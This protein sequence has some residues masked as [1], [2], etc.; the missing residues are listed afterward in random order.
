MAQS[1]CF[2][3]IGDSN[4]LRHMNRT[5]CR[6]NPLMSS[7]QVIPCTRFAVFSEALSS[8]RSSSNAVLISCSTNF[9]S[10]ATKEGTSS[11]SQ[12][13]DPVLEKF[14][15]L[16][17]DFSSMSSAESPCS[18]LVAPPMYRRSPIWYRDGLSVV[19]TRFSDSFSTRTGSVHLL[20]SFPTPEFEPDGIHVTSYSGLEF[21][22]H[23][24]DSAVVLLD[25]L[26]QSSETRLTRT[27][28]TT[29]LL[30]DRV[31]ILEQD[32]KRLNSVVELKSASIAENDDF[33]ENV[34]NEDQFVISGLERLPSDLDTKTWQIRAKSDV[35]KTIKIIAG[36][37][38][39][40]I[41]VM[42]STGRRPDALI[43][44]RVRMES[45]ADSALVRAKF[46]SFFAGGVDRRPDSLR[47][48]SVR[49]FVTQG[50]RVRLAIL[51]T[52]ARRYR[53]ANSEGRAQVIGFESRPVLKVTPP[54]GASNR[55]TRSYNY[56]EAIKSFPTCFT[57]E[58]FKPI[59]D[60]AASMSVDLRSVFVI[61][62][63][64][65]IPQRSGPSRGRNKRGPQSPAGSPQRR[66]HAAEGD[67]S[68]S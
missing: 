39:P 36:R 31:T 13:I 51:Q 38:L 26:S 52:I 32:H 28:E 19:L 24:F 15:S 67:D 37:E 22:L 54:P 29:R 8:V 61:L 10:D 44:Y 65:M 49:N 47:G 50:T 56:L 11:V 5:N 9:L 20:P 21:V 12:R 16:I 63:N 27:N 1:R 62:S 55:R 34:R 43:Q 57:D 53:D 60:K 6:S 40:I 35:Q 7:C 23:L 68:Q 2:S 18:V 45:V 14:V 3:I 42:N 48:I 41:V 64:D 58:E 33:Q 4:I 66:R 30:E 59:I 46:G 25:S 17:N